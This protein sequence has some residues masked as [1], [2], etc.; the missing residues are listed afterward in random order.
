L[1]ESF[2]Q[3]S[4]ENLIWWIGA[5]GFLILPLMGLVI[6]PKPTELAAISD[7]EGLI[8]STDQVNPE[9]E[10]IADSMLSGDSMF[11]NESIFT[12]DMDF[13]TTSI[14]ELSI[15]M[16]TDISDVLQNEANTPDDTVDMWNKESSFKLSGTQSV[17]AEGKDNDVATLLSDLNMGGGGL[18]GDNNISIP[19]AAAANISEMKFE[20]DDGSLP[21]ASVQ[22]QGGDPDDMESQLDLATAYIEIGDTASAKGV[23][24]QIILQG[25]PDQKAQAKGLQSLL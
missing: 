19:E 16:E 24:N 10:R 22:I 7:F 20:M 11:S 18:L 23:L 12:E 2:L 14:N 9:H 4:L 25:N 13:S 6:G 15:S 21:A 17:P 3:F 1:L 8:G 5:I